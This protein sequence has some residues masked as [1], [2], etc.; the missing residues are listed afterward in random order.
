MPYRVAAERQR[1]AA[2]EHEERPD[3]D[4]TRLVD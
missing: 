1:E 4:R 2:I 3:L